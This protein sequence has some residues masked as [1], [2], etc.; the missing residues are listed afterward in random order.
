MRAT[1]TKS[2]SLLYWAHTYGGH[3][4]RR[5]PAQYPVSQAHSLGPPHDGGPTASLCDRGAD[6]TCHHPP[7]VGLM[8]DRQG[9]GRRAPQGRARQGAVLRTLLLASA[10]GV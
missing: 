9:G 10:S 6:R 7:V 8:P 1:A 5:R 2:A 4:T 3:R